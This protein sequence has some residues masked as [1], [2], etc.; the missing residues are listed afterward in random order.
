MQYKQI[1]TY[2]R[3]RFALTLL[4]SETSPLEFWHFF[5]Q[6]VP[7][8]NHHHMTLQVGQSLTPLSLA[9]EKDGERV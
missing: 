9:A 1:H 6:E 8:I 5:Q 4:P 3:Q 2:T 7:S